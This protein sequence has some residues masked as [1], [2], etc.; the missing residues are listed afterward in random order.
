MLP[1]SNIFST[2]HFRAGA[3]SVGFGLFFSFVWLVALFVGRLTN[4]EIYGLLQTHHRIAYLRESR[5]VPRRP[6]STWPWRLSIQSRVRPRDFF[7]P[8]N[9]AAGGTLIIYSRRYVNRF[10]QDG[11]LWQKKAD[12]KTLR[13]SHEKLRINGQAVINCCYSRSEVRSRSLP[14]T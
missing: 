3:R 14:T 6:P 7:W 5:V 10:R 11:H 8:T 13:E 12:G 2:R 1:M 9:L 4:Q